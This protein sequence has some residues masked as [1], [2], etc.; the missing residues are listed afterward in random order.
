MLFKK[1]PLSVKQ[2]NRITLG[3]GIVIFIATFLKSNASDKLADI[4][5]E[6]KIDKKLIERGL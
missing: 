2:L 1:K 5:L 3:A 6:E 4:K